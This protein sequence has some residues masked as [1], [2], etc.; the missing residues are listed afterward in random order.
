M[1][2]KNRERE[3]RLVQAV[4]TGTLLGATAGSLASYIGN[5]Y[6]TDRH[7]KLEAKASADLQKALESSP[8]YKELA[9]KHEQMLARENRLRKAYKTKF[10]EVIKDFV[11]TENLSGDKQ[12]KAEEKREKAL[13]EFSEI[14][15]ELVQTSGRRW[16]VYGDL[17]KIDDLKIRKARREHD[18]A[19][20]AM[21]DHKARAQRRFFELTQAGAVIGVFGGLGALGLAAASRRKRPFFRRRR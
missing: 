12:K 2:K 10:D 7:V 1:A 11:G 17:S 3:M 13:S 6:S 21:H 18:L 19:V 8:A 9:V 20:K 4:L 5:S 14:S 15:R 16:K